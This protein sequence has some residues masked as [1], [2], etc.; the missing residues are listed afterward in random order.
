MPQENYTEKQILTLS[1][2]GIP[3][4]GKS[5]K[6]GPGQTR[7]RAAGSSERQ[8]Y[9]QGGIKTGRKP[10]K[11]GPGQ[12]RIRAAGSSERQG[13]RK[14]EKITINRIYNDLFILYIV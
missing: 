1:T 13:F 9:E 12:T 11:P 5:G 6:P 14:A 3:K 8:E 2:P 10:D 4:G 7:I